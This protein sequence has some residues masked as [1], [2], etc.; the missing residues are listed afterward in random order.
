MHVFF[1]I[2]FVHKTHSYA[3]FGLPEFVHWDA[4]AMVDLSGSWTAR[5]RRHR[6][7]RRPAT[8]RTVG[9]GLGTTADT[10][11]PRG[12]T[13]LDQCTHGGILPRVSRPVDQSSWTMMP[14]TM[15]V[16]PASII[17]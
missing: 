8:S 12:P 6:F 10:R 13:G 3:R 9:L 14:R 4:S 2:L 7:R 5:R 1:I 15:P 16:P 17:S 11:N